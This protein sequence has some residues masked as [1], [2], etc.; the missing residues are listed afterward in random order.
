[1]T[2]SPPT[3][4]WHRRDL[5]LEDNRG[6]REAARSGPVVPVLVLDPQIRDTAGAVRD[7]FYVASVAPLQRQYRT[8]GTD[9]AIK[10][11]APS[12]EI[13]GIVEAVGA[14]R[15]VYNADYSQLANRRDRSVEAALSEQVETTSVSDLAAHEPGSIRTSAGE[16]YSVFSYYYKKW[17][18]SDPGTPPAAQIGRASGRER[19]FPVV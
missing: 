15:L 17:A 16:H 12:E 10:V 2:D 18:D 9:L 7:A 5:R 13:P 1:M 3:V 14:D 11:G 6:L 19:V 8:L 4:F